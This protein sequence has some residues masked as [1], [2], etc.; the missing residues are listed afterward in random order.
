MRVR[1]TNQYKV[2]NKEHWKINVFIFLIVLDLLLGFRVGYLLIRNH[3][4]ALAEA[5]Q[6][7]ISPVASP[8][9]ELKIPTLNPDLTER[10]QNI[11]LIKKIWGRDSGIGLE[12]ARCESGYRTHARNVNTNST[13][14]QGVFQINSVHGMPEMEVAT[15]NISYAYTMFLKQGTNPWNSSA[16]CW[17]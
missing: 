12:I 2:K 7:I 6:T 16:K 3:G 1:G 14:D 15:A 8:K 13:V 9:E 5:Q 10:Q 17:N 11:D 4:I